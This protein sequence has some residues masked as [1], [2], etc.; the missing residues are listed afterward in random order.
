MVLWIRGC[1]YNILAAALWG[2]RCLSMVRVGGS[3]RKERDFLV[4]IEFWGGLKL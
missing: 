4:F 3:S 2:L 1:V